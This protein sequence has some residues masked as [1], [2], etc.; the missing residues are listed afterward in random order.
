MK[1][2]LIDGEFSESFDYEWTAADAFFSFLRVYP[3]LFF[4]VFEPLFVFPQDVQA[5]LWKN[6]IEKFV[7]N[8]QADSQSYEYVPTVLPTYRRLKGTYG[9]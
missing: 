2:R 6:Q 7:R 5:T 1:I 3:R 9:S 4:V 8:R